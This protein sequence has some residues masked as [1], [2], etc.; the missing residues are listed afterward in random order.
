MEL[1][2]VFNTFILLFYLQQGVFCA[3]INENTD[4][5]DER[6][7]FAKAKQDLLIIVKNSPTF[8]LQVSA[9][10]A[11]YKENGKPV[12]RELQQLQN[13]ITS[14]R[15]NNLLTIT[16]NDLEGDYGA[17]ASNPSSPSCSSSSTSDP[18]P[19]INNDDENI[20]LLEGQTYTNKSTHELLKI[21]LDELF[22]VYEF[23]FCSCCKK[24]HHHL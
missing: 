5:K 16:S 20:A 22:A 3:A 15:L 13:D 19:T 23:I 17:T 24:E 21:L 6:E 11:D 12:P 9:C 8:C 2:R 14:Q 18:S 1:I 4:S 10:I 7:L